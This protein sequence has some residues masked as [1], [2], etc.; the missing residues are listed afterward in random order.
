MGYMH[1][2]RVGSFEAKTH[3]SGLLEEVV[4][5][6][7]IIITRKGIPIAILIPYKEE[8]QSVQN[9]IDAI[10]DFRKNVHLGGLSIQE[11]KEEGR[12]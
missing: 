10:F 7:K 6:E 2:K 3:L 9:T 12:Q 5:G 4:Q 11:M 8:K 1:L